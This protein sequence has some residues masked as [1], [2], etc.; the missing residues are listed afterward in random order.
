MQFV[1]DTDVASLSM[2][3][4]ASRAAVRA[5]LEP[6]AV[7]AFRGSLNTLS[8][9]VR[10]LDETLAGGD[11]TPSR[12]LQRRCLAS[13]R[14][15]LKRLQQMTGGALEDGADDDRSESR[16]VN[17]AD[18]LQ[19]VVD[20][21]QPTCRMRRVTI[22]SEHAERDLTVIGRPA[23]LRHAMLNLAV[24]ALDAM[25][26]GGEL[27]LLLRRAGSTALI[28]VSDTGQGVASHARE[29]IWD[30][31]YSTGSGLGIGLPVAVHLVH[32]HGGSIELDPSQTGA[33]F[34]IR[35]PIL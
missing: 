4:M 31:Y 25:P 26:G 33:S 35:L 3:R 8:L 9:G 28:H 1:S 29:R 34:V 15:E 2:L 23:W 27:R 10:V 5:T 21:L 11:D 7:H 14:D 32:A 16:P 12:E 22:T 20:Q 19:G 6:G 24:N 13:L 17:L 30:M 18:V